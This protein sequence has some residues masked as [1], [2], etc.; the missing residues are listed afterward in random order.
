LGWG[1]VGEGRVYL[2]ALLHQDLAQLGALPLGGAS[3]LGALR[4]DGRSLF[5]VP[6]RDLREDSGLRVWGFGSGYP[7]PIPPHPKPQPRARPAFRCRVGGS[8]VWGRW[9]RVGGLRRGV[10]GSGSGARSRA[11]GC[12]V[13]T[14]SGVGSEYLLAP[15]MKVKAFGF[16][17]RV[18]GF[19]HR[20]DGV[21]VLDSLD[22]GSGMGVNREHSIGRGGAP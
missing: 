13:R 22:S 11:W 19:R 15:T 4:D 6:G 17:F 10:W 18:S 2:D 14:E 20:E 1:R 8:G 21:G 12:T 3:P 16:G 5:R 9:L 7:G